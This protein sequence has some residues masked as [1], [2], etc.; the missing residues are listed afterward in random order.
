MSKRIRGLNRQEGEEREEND[1]YATHVSAIPPLLELMGWEKGGLLIRENS[2]GKGHLTV[3]LQLFGHKVVATDLIDRGF[4]IPGVDFLEPSWL[5]ALKYDA[6][7]MNPPYK[8][9]LQFVRKSLE[10]APTVCAFLRI[11]FLETPKRKKFFAEHPPKY[12]AV[13]SKRMRSSKNAEF[14]EKEKGCVCYAWFVWERGF[15]GETTVKWL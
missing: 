15:K 10:I 11:S 2:C 5:D 12:V 13:F 9:A 7:V 1:F 6:V 4:G 3:P 14:P 8:Y